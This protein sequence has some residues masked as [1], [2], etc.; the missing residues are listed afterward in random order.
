MTD[1]EFR[2]EMADWYRSRVLGMYPELRPRKPR[3]TRQQYPKGLERARW[4]S[5]DSAMGMP[6]LPGVYVV[7]V[8]GRVLYVGQSENIRT[9]V[10][11]DHSIRCL[12]G[13]LKT[14]WGDFPVRDKFQ[15][16]FKISR[17]LGDWAM[18]E[19]RLIKRLRP[20]C[21]TKGKALATL[22]G[23]LHSVAERRRA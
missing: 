10:G 3:G 11:S 15:I 17:C 22:S 19:V 14:P 20:E 4:Y 13:I 8:D 18:W 21:N 1:D 16:K 5:C 23:A 2:E 12:D 7:I 6:P 9:R